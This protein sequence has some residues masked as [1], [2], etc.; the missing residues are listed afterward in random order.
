MRKSVH[1]PTTFT[2]RKSFHRATGLLYDTLAEGDL[3]PEAEPVP[4]ELLDAVEELY[5]ASAL[6]TLEDVEIS[7]ELTESEELSRRP[8]LEAD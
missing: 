3:D 8:E 5:V 1:V 2:T 7:Y 6:G 4:A